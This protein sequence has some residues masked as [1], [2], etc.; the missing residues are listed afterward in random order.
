VGYDALL[1]LRG[2]ARLAA[3]FMG[4]A[5]RKIGDDAA[6]GLRRVLNPA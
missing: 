2:L 3:P 6:G 5:F 4:K 1:E